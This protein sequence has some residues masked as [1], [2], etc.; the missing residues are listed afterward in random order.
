M[1]DPRFEKVAILGVGLIGGSLGMAVRERGLA[2]QVVAYSRTP[3]TRERAVALGAAD[4]AADSAGA[5]VAGADLVYLSVP[6]GAIVPLLA[7]VAPHL[8][9]GCLVTDAGSTKREIVEE[10]GRLDLGAACFVGGH[11]MTGSECVGVEHARADLFDQMTYV[12]TPEPTTPPVAVDQLIGLASGLGARVVRLDAAEH[13][14]AVAVISHLPHVLAWALMA[15]TRERHGAGQPVLDLAAGSWYSATRVAAADPL[16]WRDILTTNRAA[17][18]AAI[19][20][21]QAALG[22]L[23]ELVEGGC[24]NSILAALDP[25]AQAKRRHS[26]RT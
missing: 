13:D 8:R 22:E 1:D 2:T 24:E 21:F 12:V 4:A 20:D 18:V 16:L 26:E 7:E 17:V 15:V 10:V 19:G 3:A 23:K 9:P 6:V 11:P 25:L 14:E 5:C